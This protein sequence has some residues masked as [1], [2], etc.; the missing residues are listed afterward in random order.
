MHGRADM[1]SHH[2]NAELMLEKGGRVLID[3]FCPHQKAETGDRRQHEADGSTLG[4]HR[5]ISSSQKD[6][7]NLSLYSQWQQSSCNVMTILFLGKG[8][9][10]LPVRHG[11]QLGEDAACEREHIMRRTCRQEDVKKTR[12]RTRVSRGV[13]DQNRKEEIR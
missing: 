9:R 6:N 12:Q 1:V 7:E 11:G 4:R 2:T 10:S 5:S 3:P 13:G 8:S